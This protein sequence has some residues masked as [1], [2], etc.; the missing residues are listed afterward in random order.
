MIRVMTSRDVSAILRLE[1]DL[2]PIDSWSGAQFLD[3]LRGVPQTRHYIVIEEDG[4]IIG[5]AGVM[6]IA[7]NADIQTLSVAAPKQGRGLGQLLLDELEKEVVRRGAHSIFLEVRIDN[8]PALALY[9]K[10]GYA[11]L[12]RRDNYYAPGID[13]IVMRKVLS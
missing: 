10:N 9:R 13:A 7:E 1:Q 2:Y 6:V 5:Y 8:E 11:E 3:E 12:G 4:E